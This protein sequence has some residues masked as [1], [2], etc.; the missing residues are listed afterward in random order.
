MIGIMARARLSLLMALLVAASPVAAGATVRYVVAPSAALGPPASPYTTPQT[1]AATITDAL[2]VSAAGDSILVAGAPS[3]LDYTERITLT[4]GV[5]LLGGFDV[6]GTPFATRD[7][8]SIVAVIR[9]PVGNPGTVVTV[10][11]G[12]GRSTIL[13][14]FLIREGS[15]IKGGGVLAIGASPTIRGNVFYLN[16]TTS[17]TAGGGGA[18]R[19]EGN[20]TALII[21]N[22]FI[23]NTS[24]AQ[25]GTVDLVSSSPE[26]VNN[27]FFQDLV[28]AGIRCDAPSSPSIRF[29]DFHLNPSGATLG[30]CIAH[31]DSGNLFIDPLLCDANGEVFTLFQESRL[32]G[33]GEGGA[34]IGATGVGCRA[35]VK[36]VS[37][38][39]GDDYPYSAPEGAA[40]RIE[41][42]LAITTPGDTVKVAE[43]TFAG[44][45][46]IPAGI[47][48]EGSW[49]TIFTARR[50]FGAFT[51][52]SSDSTLQGPIVSF[53][54]DGGV[55][56]VL[57]GFV[58]TGGR[59][60]EGSAVRVTN[61]SPVLRGL[62]VLLNTCGDS[63]GGA[64]HVNGGS[65]EIV[66]TLIAINRGAGVSCAG[67]ATPNV[68]HSGFFE[69]SGGET[70]GCPDPLPPSVLTED[71]FFCDAAGCSVAADS[72]T[73]T[74]ASGNFHLFAESRYNVGGD[75]GGVIGNLVAECNVEFHYVS[76]TGGNRF[77]YTTPADAA[78]SIG[79]AL[80]V[81]SPLDE[82]KVAE[83]AYVEAIELAAG[84]RMTGGWD[85][86]FA[87]PRDPVAKTTTILGDV[88]G[89]ATVLAQ[90]V[91]VDNLTTLD[92]F[93]ISHNIGVD[94][95][96]IEIR[97][98]ATPTI[99]GNLV[100]GNT[101]TREGAGIFIE[102]AEPIVRNNTVFQNTTTSGAGYRSGGLFVREA[103]RQ[104]SLSVTRNIF[105][106]NRGGYGISCDIQNP[107]QEQPPNSVSENIAF[108]NEGIG[109]GDPNISSSDCPDI[110]SRNIRS[111][112]LFCDYGA[113]DITIRFDSPGNLVGCGQTV[114]GARGVGCI[115]PAA[116]HSWYIKA[117]NPGA[118]YP[119]GAPSCAASHMSDVMPLV[120]PGD[121]VLFG[122]GTYRLRVY[123]EVVGSD[124]TVYVDTMTVVP[125]VVYRGN[126]NDDFTARNSETT[127][128]GESLRRVL[129]VP[130]GIDSTTV[131]DGFSF[132]GGNAAGAA[133]GGLYVSAGSSPILRNIRFMFHQADSGGAAIY[134]GPGSAPKVRFCYF[135]KIRVPVP[136]SSQVTLD[137]SDAELS[138]CTFFDNLTM[139]IDILSGSPHV[140]NNILFRNDR[141]GIRC[142]GGATPDLG[143]NN[144]YANDDF[145]YSLCS[146]SLLAFN[147]SADP[148]FCN[149]DPRALPLFDHSPSAGTGRGGLN[150]GA[151]P[152][153]CRTTRHF[154]SLDGTP[155]FP[156]VCPDSASSSLGAALDLAGRNRLPSSSQDTVFVATGVYN[157]D[158]VVP[159][160]VILLGGY[161][162]DF[163]GPATC[164][165]FNVAGRDPEKYPVLIRGTGGGSVA[166]YKAGGDQN[167]SITD[168]I[169][170][171]GGN[172]ARGGGIFIE[173]GATHLIRNCTVDSCA[174]SIEGGGV[175][176]SPT[177]GAR[178]WFITAL[179]N[180]A[181]AGAAIFAESTTVSLQKW[182]IVENI[183]AVGGGAAE[184]RRYTGEMRLMLIAGND[185]IGALGTNTTVLGGDSRRNLFWDNSQG[186]TLG[187]RFPS[188]PL[189]R[190]GDPR[191]CG[192]SSG[193]LKVA[194]KSAAVIASP[195]GISCARSDLNSAE[196]I[197]RY[198]VGCT[199]PGHTF[200]VQ[201][202]K[203]TPGSYPF[204]CAL[205]AAQ[206]LSEVLALV[207]SRADSTDTV[208]VSVGRMTDNA[209]LARR[210]VVLGGWNTAFTVRNPAVNVTTI[211]PRAAGSILRIESAKD[212]DGVV[213]P[214][215]IVDTTSIVD[216]ITFESGNAGLDNG[217]GI[218]CVD[219][220]PRITNNV[221][222]T[223]RT[224]NFG[225]GLYAQ[226]SKD[227][228]IR[229]NRFLDNRAAH[230]GAIYLDDCE[231]P[232]VSANQ[233]IANRAD[234]R[235]AGI[236]MAH[237]VGAAV[238]DNNTV[239]NNKGDGISFA[240]DDAA[241]AGAGARS[242]I[243]NNVIAFNTQTGLE[244]Y[245]QSSADSMPVQDHNLHWGNRE[246]NFVGTTA[247]P[248]DVF[249]D[250][251]F[252][253]PD[254]NDFRLQACSP[255]IGGGR[256]SADSVIGHLGNANSRCPDTRDPA[257]SVAF[258]RNTIV[259]RFLDVYVTFSEVVVDST[260]SVLRI[261]ENQPSVPLA[262]GRS[263]S[264]MSV[265]GVT[266]LETSNCGVLTVQV[267][268]S[269]ACGN[270]AQFS[271]EASTVVVAPGAGAL[272]VSK[273][274]DVSVEVGA[275][276]GGRESLLLVASAKSSAEDAGEQGALES[277]GLPVGAAHEILGVADLAGAGAD[278]ALRFRLPS[279][280]PSGDASAVAI[281]RRLG[282]GWVRVESRLDAGAR[283]LVA[284]GDGDG[285]YRLVLTGDRGVSPALPRTLSLLPSAPNPA[286]G[287]ALFA[288]D[289][290]ERAHARLSVYDASGRRVATLV[291]ETLPPG[292]HAFH[293]P[294]TDAS[295]R[296][297]P[298]GVYFYELRSGQVTETRKLVLV[299]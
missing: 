34:D 159:P 30:S 188:N 62:S 203:T 231:R 217:G 15:A 182:T 98:G 209:S 161:P 221:F 74:F 122:L 214:E 254:T 236:R 287:H 257:I 151:F 205:T 222:R 22:S 57:D 125:G 27:I 109:G 296:R 59:A 246:G 263:D 78:T 1:A 196:V 9:A 176:V 68:H 256:D 67:G 116:P 70:A 163:G 295:G 292:R 164:G 178:M 177:S 52:L 270:S 114:I 18:I 197:G 8:D 7:P 96:G 75:D 193:N 219:A 44:Q 280:A 291:E 200:L 230:G 226:R 129:F 28:G 102:Q 69:N 45:V 71:P 237:H 10:A 88:P 252:C 284:P 149:L 186:D 46:S 273:D 232:T 229:S 20:S 298:S 131:I 56:A 276:H 272:L 145:Q 249:L 281:Y 277:L 157:E 253:S 274:G 283:A 83:G 53:D 150:M 244:R 73:C 278:V 279:D 135:N 158:V 183:A 54:D 168:G 99:V 17:L 97:N 139:G 61:A 110:F 51:A 105:Y 194:Y 166:T 6:A 77:P 190:F 271:R 11:T 120:R 16:Q 154:V 76:P 234:L 206:T 40:L 156:Y 210:A 243:Y 134:C 132:S 64:I 49:N 191:F 228:P 201:P 24:Q 21:G 90:G 181:P 198:P 225:G 147:I 238:I 55:P 112:P 262:V 106:D 216:G 286:P 92:G 38:I 14:G 155:G 153:G 103:D 136:K 269:D 108:A 66:N 285:I 126:Y 31:P 79:V 251:L 275:G 224:D 63:L 260:L 137:G 167:N 173:R 293:W 50:V 259:P 4:A 211:T 290:P 43:G 142:G 87:P 146:D 13:E 165:G 133:G 130:T 113:G 123:T 29:N 81:A 111:D 264:A 268:A 36:Y 204:A 180:T 220:S 72:V 12:A 26:I 25:S 60:N 19:L 117:G 202:G 144:A 223:N 42:A 58:V 235:G 255:A 48:V 175:Y 141:G 258:L 84:V 3:L 82:V 294:G 124:S 297:L 265:Y 242:Q 248:G 160:N 32:F 162:P 289:L 212:I 185:A 5:V 195:S 241:S 37:P 101:T 2:A 170:F 299:R 94:G 240:G 140:F 89:E 233:L 266:G 152:V 107:D 288:F 184:F 169:N 119:Y 104:T 121:T 282:S 33:A 187:V 174:A 247:G 215:S 118:R 207:G 127:L 95:P 208:R 80:A 179:R 239:A 171:R 65:P 86:T 148:L 128:N 245:P 143:Q 35:R 172:A 199:D 100:T 192:A 91:L 115:N 250:P 138:N 93:T 227:Q 213:I 47:V 267:D 218:A 189:L 261:C 85:T 41:D 23:R 39:G